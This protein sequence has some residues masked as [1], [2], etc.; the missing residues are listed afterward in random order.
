MNIQMGCLQKEVINIGWSKYSNIE[1]K[2]IIN[3][4]QIVSIMAC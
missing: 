2:E 3:N 4:Y 1:I